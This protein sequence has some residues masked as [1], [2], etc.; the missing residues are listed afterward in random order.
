MK[1]NK[2]AIGFILLSLSTSVLGEAKLDKVAKKQTAAENDA[3]TS[4]KKINKL[5]DEAAVLLQKYRQTLKKIE[6][7]KVYNEQLRKLIEQQKQEKVDVVAQIDSLKNTNQG[8]VPLMLKM[9]KTLEE[10]VKLDVPFLPE[11]RNKRI[12]DITSM[13]DRADISTSEKF[14]RVLE[15]YQ[16]ENEYGRTI[17]AYRGI[18]K[19]DQKDIT[20]DFLRLGRISLMYQTLDGGVSAMWDHDSGKWVDLDSDF[21]RGIK[22][23]LAMARKQR[24]PSLIKMPITKPG[25]VL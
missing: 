3:R 10:F 22:E 1:K 24:A 12:T 7:A 4:Q 6:N 11:E 25:S 14:R 15:A 18:V 2:L 21:K 16:V 13:M 17:E 23:G 9:T 20:V 19:R 8:I 5:D